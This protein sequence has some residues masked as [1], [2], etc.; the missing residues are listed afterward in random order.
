M[1]VEIKQ[2]VLKVVG[3]VQVN[4]LVIKINNELDLVNKITK[5]TGVTRINKVTG[6][7]NELD[8]NNEIAKIA[9]KVDI[10]RIINL[11]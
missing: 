5:I 11:S 6:A 3:V 1:K 10:Y 8:L 4:G 7:D 9:N 2:I